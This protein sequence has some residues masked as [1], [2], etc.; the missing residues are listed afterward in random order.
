ML[1]GRLTP[2][3]C[4][5]PS[6]QFGRTSAPAVPQFAHT[7]RDPKGTRIWPGNL[8]ALRMLSWRHC[9]QHTTRERMPDNRIS[10]IVLGAIRLSGCGDAISDHRTWRMF[11]QI[12]FWIFRGSRPWA[13]VRLQKLA[14]TGPCFGGLLFCAAAVDSTFR[15]GT[16]VPISIPW[17]ARPWWGFFRWKRHYHLSKILIGY[18][19]ATAVRILRCHLSQNE[20]RALF[21]AKKAGIVVW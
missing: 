4:R 7:I 15:A 1:D 14:V 19:T 2:A 12:N 16:S 8:S 9:R 6:R 13:S 21:A 5:D 11:R 18:T 10:P 17:Q 3:L 20:S